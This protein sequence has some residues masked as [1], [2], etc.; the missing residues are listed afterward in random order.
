LYQYGGIYTDMD[1]A[2]GPK[3]ENATIIKDDDDAWFV[4]ERI[5]IPSQYFM[6]ASPRHPLMYLLVTVTL[7]RLLEVQDVGTQYV[8]YVTGPGALKEA[9]MLF[10]NSFSTD[11]GENDKERAAEEEAQE[12][13]TSRSD[14]DPAASEHESEAS[15]GQRRRLLETINANSQRSITTTL[16][17]SKEKASELRKAEEEAKNERKRQSQPRMEGGVYVGML[18]RTVTIAGNRGVRAEFCVF[19]LL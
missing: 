12:G 4:V 9:W 6:A 16:K 11:S 18:N 2:P 3:F 15:Q 17:T 13:D 1:A 14:R 7:R 5:G 10:T 19:Q 8:P